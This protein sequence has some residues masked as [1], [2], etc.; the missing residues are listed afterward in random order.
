[1]PSKVHQNINLILANHVRYLFIGWTHNIAP[2]WN[3][4]A[5]ALC[6]VILREVVVIAEQFKLALVMFGKNGLYEMD[7]GM[8][9]EIR[10]QIANA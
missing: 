10:R 1:M 3:H 2:V 7:H 4:G 5:N 9:A 6:D 8:L